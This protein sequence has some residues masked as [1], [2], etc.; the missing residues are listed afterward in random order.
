MIS[1]DCSLLIVSGPVGVG[2]TT[3]AREVSAKLTIANV[4]HTFVDLDALTYTTPR[5]STDR[6]GD[7][8]ALKN[9]TEIWKNGKANGARNLIVAR[10]CESQDYANKIANSVG[11]K[12]PI[13]V[14]LTASKQTLLERVQIREVGSQLDWHEKRSLELYYQMVKYSFEKFVFETD[15]RTVEEV[16]HEV[17]AS[18]KWSY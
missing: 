17:I 13:V 11:L 18:V 16:A 1:N 8:L 5:P 2:K 15:D 14:R 3:V 7:E 10:V 6:W 4:P 12:A 9:L